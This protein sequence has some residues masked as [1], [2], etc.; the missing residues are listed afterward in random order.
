MVSWSFGQILS[1]NLHLTPP[2]P[3]SPVITVII[4]IKVDRGALRRFEMQPHEKKH[5]EHA[6][7]QYYALPFTLEKTGRYFAVGSPCSYLGFLLRQNI[8]SPKTARMI[9][10]TPELGSP[11]GF[12]WKALR[13]LICMRVDVW[14]IKMWREA[15]SEVELGLGLF[16]LQPHYFSSPMN[17]QNMRVGGNTAHQQTSKTCWTSPAISTDSFD[18]NSTLEGIKIAAIDH[19]LSP[20]T[21]S[22]EVGFQRAVLRSVQIRTYQVSELGVT[23]QDK[24]NPMTI[25]GGTPLSSTGDFGTDRAESP[26]ARNY[27]IAVTATMDPNAV[28][29]HSEAYGSAWGLN[30]LGIP[31]TPIGLVRRISEN[32]RASYGREVQLNTWGNRGRGRYGDPSD[33]FW[34]VSSK[35]LDL[36]AYNVFPWVAG[37]TLSTDKIMG[38]TS[39]ISPLQVYRHIINISLFY[40]HL[41][42]MKPCAIGIIASVGH[43]VDRF[44]DAI[45]R[46]FSGSPLLNCSCGSFFEARRVRRDVL[47]GKNIASSLEGTLTIGDAFREFRRAEE[48]VAIATWLAWSTSALSYYTVFYPHAFSGLWRTAE[49]SRTFYNGRPVPAHPLMPF[50]T[51][52]VNPASRVKGVSWSSV[53]RGENLSFQEA[54]PRLAYNLPIARIGGYPA[55]AVDV[56]SVVCSIWIWSAGFGPDMRDFRVFA[57][58]SLWLACGS[59]VER[60]RKNLSELSFLQPPQ[61]TP[62]PK[63]TCIHGQIVSSHCYAAPLLRRTSASSLICFLA[64]PQ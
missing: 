40:G 59:S 10:I 39:K 30:D 7:M 38:F 27:V 18:R 49:G 14:M 61:R 12:R 53:G 35:L 5:L 32:Y 28:G 15:K 1:P 63:K 3:A 21:A 9:Q 24:I 22:S 25:I 2:H 42:S 62:Q 52:L 19:I 6:R 55:H 45:N 17:L 64:R 48:K 8:L 26:R 60:G 11:I 16:Q 44:T 43:A 41:S 31:L 34:V 54:S 50:G 13:M 37:R 57:W 51:S 23:T 47:Q 58:L 46:H 33:R 4:T 29:I 36:F 56:L 20:T